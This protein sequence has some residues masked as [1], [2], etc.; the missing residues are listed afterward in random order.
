MLDLKTNKTQA[1]IKLEMALD[2]LSGVHQALSEY[3]KPRL[4]NAIQSL[5]EIL[6]YIKRN[7]N[8]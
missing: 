6:E 1:I 7:I 3:S 8:E 2:N 5:S 4:E